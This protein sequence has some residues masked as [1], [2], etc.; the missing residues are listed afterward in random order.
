[1][2]DRLIARRPGQGMVEYALIIS[3]VVIVVLAAL[4]LFGPQLASIFKNINNN[5]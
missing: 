5:L 1:M 4:I 2:V 3:L